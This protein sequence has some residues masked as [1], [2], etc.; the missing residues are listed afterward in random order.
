[1]TG[2][3]QRLKLKQ[4]QIDTWSVREQLSLA[5]AVLRSGDQNWVSVS[6]TMKQCGE[7]GRPGDWFSQKNCALQYNLLQDKFQIKR[8]KRGEKTE[9]GESP[10]ELM[11]SRL[12]AQRMEELERIVEE[13]RLEILKLE[14]Q[15][16]QLSSDNISEERLQ[17]ILREVEEEEAKEDQREAEHAAWLASR[18]AKKL[19]IQ[20]ALKTSSTIPRARQQQSDQSGS[21]LD[22]LDS[23]LVQHD[24]VDPT[25]EGLDRGGEGANQVAAVTTTTQASPQT[26]S[27]S[28]LLTALLHS[29][30]RPPLPSPPVSLPG[31]PY[32]T[33]AA[34]NLTA[35]LAAL[36][37]IPAPVST[38]ASPTA[39]TPPPLLPAPPPVKPDVD[40]DTTLDDIDEI[41]RD[42]LR[43][44]E[45]TTEDNVEIKQDSVIAVTETEEQIKTEAPVEDMKTEDSKVT[46]VKDVKIEDPEPSLEA[47]ESPSQLEKPSEG[48]DTDPTAEVI[49]LADETGGEALEVGSPVRQAEEDRDYRAWKKAIIL[50]WEQIAQ[51]KN[52]N[53]FAS[54]VSEAD[55]P[56]YRDIVYR[57]MDLNS[58]KRNVESG[59]IRGTEEFERDLALMFFNAIMYNSSDHDVS[60][61]TR[62]MHEDTR[63]IL[64]DFKATQGVEAGSS[65]SK[66][67]RG[68]SESLASPGEAG[69]EAG[70]QR[71]RGRSVSGAAAAAPT[72][73][74]ETT[75]RKRER[76]GSNMDTESGS[77]PRMEKKR[78]LI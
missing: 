49:K 5:S 24:A 40:V 71:P 73:P 50:V 64:R 46:D 18:E 70:G 20:Q 30:S 63:R 23:P 13:D 31:S 41:I 67:L 22:S 28:P 8:P 53:L 47:P 45:E 77:S 26:A 6:R 57:P 76:S 33:P 3:Q 74:H 60:A 11:V 48:V 52:A 29:P 66:A 9:A 16:E 78:K 27:S 34:T 35:R 54:A 15:T 61:L 32:K 25:E 1:M 2:V 4:T 42:K 68:K 39:A 55:A 12:S 72:Q 65:D 14:E 21:E 19:E 75:S 69:R 17:A 7:P 58:L 44:G 51:H 37:P 43:E 59:H 56:E 62:H 36:S 38:P 10:V